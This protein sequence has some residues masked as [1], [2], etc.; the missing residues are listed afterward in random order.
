MVE[1]KHDY[2]LVKSLY[3]LLPLL[4]LLALD[5]RRMTGRRQVSKSLHL[6][7]LSSCVAIEASRSKIVQVRHFKLAHEVVSHDVWRRQR[8]IL[9]FYQ[10]P[11]LPLEELSVRKWVDREE[12]LNPVHD[13]LDRKSLPHSVLFADI[14][15]LDRHSNLI[16]RA[17]KHRF[18]ILS[19]DI[20][21]VPSRCH[22]MGQR[23]IMLVREYLLL[24]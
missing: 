5:A 1:F 23:Q 2:F 11:L 14:R 21:G 17:L 22:L 4:E 24:R 9:E 16:E 7:K 6:E 10:L 12:V 19:E 18:L 20:L 3:V 8:P 15:A 13:A